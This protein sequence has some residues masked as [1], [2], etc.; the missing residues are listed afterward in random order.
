MLS[1]RDDVAAGDF[2]NSDSAIGFVGSIQVNVVR[3]DASGDGDLETLGLGQT[4][5][6]EVT[7][8]ETALV[9]FRY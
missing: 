5:C 1:H 2:S 7:G 8:V 6:G 3:A 4:L 9:R